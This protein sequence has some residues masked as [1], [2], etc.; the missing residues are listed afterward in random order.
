[1]K[2]KFNTLLKFVVMALC[3]ASAWA[4]VT[5]NPGDILVTDPSAFNGHGAVLRI[6]PTSGA[7][8]VVS[9]GGLFSR[10]TALAIEADGKIVTANRTLPGVVRVDPQTGGQTIVASQPIVDPF[11]L[12]LEANGSI[13]VS[14]LGCRDHSCTSGLPRTPAV[15]RIDP[16]SGAVTTVSAGGYLDSPFAIDVEANGGILVTD[17]TS[18]VLPLTGQGGIIRIDPVTGAQTIVSRGQADYG[19][20]FGI[21]IEPSGTILNTVLTLGGYGCAPSAIFR[22]NPT[23]DQNTPFSPHSMNWSGPFGLAVDT[24]GSVVVAEEG[25]QAIFR[26]DAKTGFPTQISRFGLLVA[27]TDVAIA[28]AAATLSVT[29]TSTAATVTAGDGITYTYTI[30]V[31]NS[32]GLLASGVT[33]MDSWPAGFV[34]GATTASQGSCTSGD[35]FT[36][37]LGDLPPNGS[38]TITVNYTV[39]STTPAGTQTSTLSVSSNTPDTNKGNKTATNTVTVNTSADLSVTK[40]DGV[41]TVTAGDGM[42]RTYTITVSNAG[43]SLALA[44]VLSD[45]WPAGFIPGGVTTSQGSCSSTGGNFTCSLGTLSTGASAT[46]SATYTVPATT[47]AGNQTNSVSVTSNTPD[48]NSSNNTAVKSTI[49]ITSADLTVTKSDGVTTVTAGDGVTRTYTIMV[50]NAGPS[51]AESVSLTDNWP[52]GFASGT[53]S[54]SQGTCSAGPNFSCSLGSLPAGGS[55]TI[56]AS[57]TVPATTPAGNQTNSVNVTSNTPDS[58]SSNNSASKT[59]TVVTSADMSVTKTDGVTSVGLLDLSTHTYTIV[60]SNA[61]PSVAVGVTLTDTW[62][63]GFTRG[64]TTTTQGSCTPGSSS[65][66]C[67]L[68]NLSPGSSVIVKADY[69]VPLVTTL[70]GSHTNTVTVSSSTLDPNTANNQASKTTTVAL[71]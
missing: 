47:P 28:H 2:W 62:P 19:C 16:V 10:P 6:D 29:L 30:I 26:A 40:S 21:A 58:N 37:S 53:I 52:S 54:T 64:N 44:V 22:A 12:A 39:P 15:Y 1:M 70:L 34:R 35:S 55:A 27:P 3:S 61:G 45:A 13:V 46:I 57:Y 32:G 18:S 66:T 49:V 23:I 56:R 5:I 33:L 8:T 14:D 4:Q 20:P 31:N 67:S 42:T 7:Q 71:F 59:T 9:Q 69:T 51:P 25:W 41:T 68:G 63:S 17:A 11:G 36:C 50:S 38:A 43:P 48:P 24:D 60:V 65:F